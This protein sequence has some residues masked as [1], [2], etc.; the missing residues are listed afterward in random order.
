MCFHWFHHN[1][2]DT[3]TGASGEINMCNVCSAVSRAIHHPVRVVSLAEPVELSNKLYQQVLTASA[4]SRDLH[5]AIILMRETHAR[6]GELLESKWSAVSFER[7]EIVLKPIKTAADPRV[8]LNEA[9]INVLRDRKTKANGDEFVFPHRS[10]NSMHHELQQLS[11]RI[12][13]PITWHQ[14]R[15]ASLK[16]PEDDQQ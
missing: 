15:K 1:F 8:L 2:I 7:R 3:R 13:L 5:D 16:K 14:I 11:K 6:L 12:G 9:A 10:R 4:S